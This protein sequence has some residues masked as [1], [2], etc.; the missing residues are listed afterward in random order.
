[1]SCAWHGARVRAQ[2]EYPEGKNVIVEGDEGNSFYI[3]REGEVGGR[4]TRPHAPRW[5][6]RSYEVRKAGGR[7]RP[8]GGEHL[9]NDDDG[10]IGSIGLMA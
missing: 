8:W 7:V 5:A 6:A 4:A 10:S 9:S 2:A 1:M 3:I